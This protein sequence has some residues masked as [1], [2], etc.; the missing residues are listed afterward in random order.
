VFSNGNLAERRSKGDGQKCEMR[1]I[2]I[3][4]TGKILLGSS[5]QENYTGETFSMH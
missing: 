4:V 1:G 2:M 3:H 5:D